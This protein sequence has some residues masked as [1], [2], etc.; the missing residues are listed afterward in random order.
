M[1]KTIIAI[2]ACVLSLGAWAQNDNQTTN[3]KDGMQTVKFKTSAVCEMCKETL[4]KAMAYEKGVKE[5]N[6]N[7]DSKI[8][9][10]T[11]DPKKTSIEKLK[12]AVSKTGYDADE[13]PAEPKAYEHLNACCKKDAVH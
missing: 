11:F 12:I 8:L 4:E 6:L 9:S 5:S 2:V 13:L 3:N 1:K 10:I 7:V